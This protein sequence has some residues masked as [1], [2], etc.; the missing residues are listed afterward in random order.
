M[1][2][3]IRLATE[4]DAE[5]MLD[6]YA[7]VVRDTVISFE[8]QPPSIKDFRSRIRSVLERMPWLVCVVGDEIAGYAYATPFRSRAGYRWSAELTVY[9]HPGYHRRGVGRALYT[10]LLCCLASQG[11][12]TA[13]AIIAL[14]N[15]ASIGLHESLGFRRTGV[16]ENIG[17]K[18]GKWIDDDVWQLDIQP[19]PPA[20]SEPIHLSDL[21]ETPEWVEALECGVAVLTC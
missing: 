17:F 1:D 16:L 18:H 5:Q 4:A 11:Y 7:P 12:R 19:N 8:E 14:P 6:I 2:A 13:V 15:P 21:I 10:A 3:G 9:V 20:P